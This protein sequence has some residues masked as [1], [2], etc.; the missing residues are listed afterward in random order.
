MQAP[1]RSP[2]YPH[3]ARLILIASM[4]PT[5]GLGIGRFGLNHDRPLIGRINVNPPEFSRRPI[6]RAGEILSVQ[7]G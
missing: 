2:P 6:G 1:D 3:P 7:C 4:A 5:I